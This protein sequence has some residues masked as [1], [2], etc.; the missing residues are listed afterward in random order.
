M[1][2]LS[3]IKTF[4]TLAEQESFSG[5]ARQ[6][7]LAQSTVSLQV[8]K[9]EEALGV[10]LIDRKHKGCTLTF[11]GQAVLPHAKAL[12]HSADQFSNAASG[13]KITIGC[14]GNI[15]AYYFSEDLKRFLDA[16]KLDLEW[17]IRTATNPEIAE[18]LDVGAIDLG[19][20][21][22]PADRR[23]LE[24]H[25]WRTEPMVVIVPKGHPLAKARTI[26]RDELL[27]LELI[28]GEPG[29]GTGTLLK[30]V[31]GRRADKLK[32]T[33]NLQSTEAVKCAVKA[34]LG[35]SIVLAGAVRE[36]AAGKRLA[37]LSIKDAQLEKTLYLALQPGLPANALPKRLT[38]FLLR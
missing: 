17:E 29:S 23:S 30:R 11:R 7:G 2:N 26:A 19:A 10:S 25:A 33:H 18:M 24:I 20:M 1:L 3:F 28:G 5:A 12:L 34:G 6:L 37:I 16:E 14:S 32:I 21:E 13:K 36:E 22:W 31:F 35:C 38:E 27:Q 15:A 9:L 8:R 4:V